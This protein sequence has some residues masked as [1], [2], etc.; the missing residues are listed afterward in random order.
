MLI[1]ISADNIYKLIHQSHLT[2]N[3]IKMLEKYS[4]KT[5]ECPE[6]YFALIAVQPDLLCVASCTHA[7]VPVALSVSQPFTRRYSHS[8]PN[9]NSVSSVWTFYTGN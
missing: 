3:Y 8:E 9:T 5:R 1:P 7:L 6:T 2:T 4:V